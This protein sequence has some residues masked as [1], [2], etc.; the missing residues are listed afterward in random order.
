MGSYHGT[1]QASRWRYLMVHSMKSAPG[2][3]L[4][5]SMIYSYTDYL[6]I[7]KV[8]DVVRAVEGKPNGSY[9]LHDDG[10]NTAVIARVMK[11]YFFIGGI[12]HQLSNNCFLELVSPR[13]PTWE[14]LQV[15]DEIK[16][17][18][19]GIAKVLEVGASGKTFL[20]SRFNSYEK[21]DGWYH[22]EEAKNEGWTLVTPPVEPEVQEMTVEEVSKLVGKKVKIVE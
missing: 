7:A 4:K 17:P 21:I 9:L 19:V 22:I 5:K 14:T 18:Y 16:I 1:E 12:A 10:S 6:K 8:G 11:D 2:R 15:G 3:K 13:I 20:C